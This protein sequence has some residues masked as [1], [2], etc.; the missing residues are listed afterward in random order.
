MFTYLA[1]TIREIVKKG[2]RTLCCYGLRALLRMGDQHALLPWGITQK[3]MCHAYSYIY[4]HFLII[5]FPAPQ[6]RGTIAYHT[7]SKKKSA[8]THLYFYFFGVLYDITRSE[9]TFERAATNRRT[10]SEAAF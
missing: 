6:S 3:N 1:G 9:T 8:G 10:G 7:A 2:Q 5:N 4:C